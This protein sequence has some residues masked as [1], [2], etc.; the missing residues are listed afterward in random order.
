MF[1]AAK[2]TAGTMATYQIIIDNQAND[3]PDKDSSF[4]M[5]V[6]VKTDY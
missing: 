1:E 3:I 6:S 5:K 2:N 4:P